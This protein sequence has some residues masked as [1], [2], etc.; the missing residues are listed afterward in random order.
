M[1]YNIHLNAGASPVGEAVTR[2]DAVAFIY[3]YAATRR[4]RIA[5]LEVDLDEDGVDAFLTSGDILSTRKVV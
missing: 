2:V 5:A 4:L 1:P 3:I